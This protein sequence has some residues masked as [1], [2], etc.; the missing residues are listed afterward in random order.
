MSSS[1]RFTGSKFTARAAL[2][3]ERVQRHPVAEVVQRDR[4]R[5]SGGA[6]LLDA[7]CAR[8]ARL[9]RRP[10][11]VEQQQHRQVASTP[12][13]VEI[14]GLV[15]HDAGQHLDA[16]LDRGVDVDVVTLSLPMASVQT[17]PES[18]ERPRHTDRVVDRPGRRGIDGRCDFVDGAPIGPVTRACDVPLGI[19]E[20]PGLEVEG[21]PGGGSARQRTPRAAPRLAELVRWV[22]VS[23]PGGPPPSPDVASGGQ[24]LVEPFADEA[25]S[26]TG[27]V[28]RSVP[29][30]VA[31]SPSSSSRSSSR[32]G[33][34]G[35]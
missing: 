10:G 5:G 25:S 11:D 28:N 22:G 35:T 21:F 16:G 26:P 30:V 9:G 3:V 31:N 15:G 32:A 18:G 12:Q 27:L 23:A 34:R 33:R 4:Q 14:D 1:N 17:Q 7:R 19:G 24:H 2:R 8:R 6:L 20:S 29:S 13:A